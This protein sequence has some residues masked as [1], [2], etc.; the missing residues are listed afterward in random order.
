LARLGATGGRVVAIKGER[1]LPVDEL[2]S[3]FEAWLPAYMTTPV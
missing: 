3:R 1:P 2:K